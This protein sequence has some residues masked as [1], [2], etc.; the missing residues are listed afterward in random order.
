[1]GNR[2]AETTQS[3]TNV[4]AFNNLN[5]LTVYIGSSVTQTVSGYTSSAITSSTINTVPATISNGT[6][7]TANVPVPLGTNILT[8]QAQNSAGTYT[9]QKVQAVTT[10]G[11]APAA[12]TYDLNG[13]VTK[14]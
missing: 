13:N 10:S 6:N 8:V 4:G 5:Q 9:Q 2:L 11:S 3:G 14:D 7:F 1:M 12:L